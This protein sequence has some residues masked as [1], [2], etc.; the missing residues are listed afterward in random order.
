MGDTAWMVGLW[1]LFGGSHVAL[2]TR[3]VRNGLVR[4]FGE[5]G[6]GAAFV[7]VASLLFTALV[8]GYAGV[9]FSGPPGIALATVS[10]LRAPLFAAIV[11]G[12]MLMAGA[13]APSG[14]LETPVAVL[15]EGVRPAFGL[16][17]IT[18]HPF[19]AGTVLVMGAHALLATH[20]TGT[21]F[22]AGFVILATVGPIHQA[23]KLRARKGTP[24]VAYLHSTSAI[25]FVAIL[26][27]RQRLALG[28]LPWLAFAIGAL[29][30][31][32]VREL[33]D[34]L[35]A[36]HG[37]PFIAVVVGGSLVLGVFADRRARRHTA[38]VEAPLAN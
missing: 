12:F 15:G 33:H 38:N 30:A 32:G 27:G 4:R 2:A 37:A 29:V 28:E 31:F 36:W 18:R 9:R 23:Q 26:R 20:A 5:R 13:L 24:F 8:V 16:E 6:F 7:V 35:F 3:G 22:F 19:F 10:W 21:I 17:R 14:Y 34:W 25:P 11:L 1:L